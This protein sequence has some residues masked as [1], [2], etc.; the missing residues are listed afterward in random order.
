MKIVSTREAARKLG[1]HFTTLAHYIAAG[2][3]PM[4]TILDV[5]SSKLHAWTEAEIEHVRQLLPKIANG[6]KTRY[7]K[8]KAQPKGAVPHKKR[9]PKK[10]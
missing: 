9:K 3:V 7:Q 2:K 4:P 5:G 6:R 10:K 1:I 8:Q